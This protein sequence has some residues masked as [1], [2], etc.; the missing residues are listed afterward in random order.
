MELA[1]TTCSMTP[2]G[3]VQTPYRASGVLWG[4]QIRKSSGGRWTTGSDGRAPLSQAGLVTASRP[5]AERRLT[6]R[7]P[8]IRVGPPQ[9][10]P[11]DRTLTLPRMPFDGHERL[12]AM[13]PLVRFN[14]F[15][16]HRVV[17]DNLVKCGVPPELAKLGLTIIPAWASGLLLYGSYARGD[18]IADSDVDLLALVPNMTS[19]GSSGLASLSCYTAEQLRS[20]RGTLFGAHLARDGRIIWDPT[21]ELS[22]ALA[23]MGSVDAVR[24]FSR[25]RHLAQVLDASEDDLA[26]SLPGLLREAKYLLRSALYGKA[27]QDGDP[28]FSVRELAERHHDD[29]LATLLASRDTSAGTREVFRDLVLRLSRAIG[30]LPTNPHGSLDALIVNSWE[31]DRDLATVG[32][33]AR[34]R[35]SADPY[36]E[37]EKVLL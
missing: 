11:A 27:I 5:R 18:F 36:E 12:M 31:S 17:M 33:M 32:V 23:T 6:K 14:S 1:L 29:R 20:A 35:P 30:E 22:A 2:S 24:L 9:R 8:A 37:F 26:T 13:T 10:L 28:C 3:S 34:G 19:G 15:K 25:I 4:C 16:E 21:G 7:V